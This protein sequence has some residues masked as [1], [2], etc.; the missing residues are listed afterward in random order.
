MTAMIPIGEL[1]Q[2]KTFRRFFTTTPDLYPTQLTRAAWRIWVKTHTNSAWRRKD[3]VQYQAGV[4]FILRGIDEGSVHDAVLQSRG[5]SYKPPI[6]HVR[7][8]K[9]GEP[10]ILVGADGIPRPKVTS[11][12]W[13]T[14]S[15]L[16]QDYG[17]HEWCF[18]CRRPT[19]FGYFAQHHNFRGTVL[20]GF[21][22]GSV[23]RCA[24]CGISIDSIRRS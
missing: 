19:I 1:L 20:E 24:V 12:I 14:P 11:S 9:N 5:V 23:R 17:S 22:D 10:I 8:I 21:Y 18:Y 7:A 15:Q 2:D 4:R 3:V 13:R 16:I 6:R